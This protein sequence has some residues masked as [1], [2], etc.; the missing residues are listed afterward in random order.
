MTDCVAFMTSAG[1][2]F[3][4]GIKVRMHKQS[5]RNAHAVIFVSFDKHQALPERKCIPAAA[6]RREQSVNIALQPETIVYWF[7]TDRCVLANKRFDF[8]NTAFYLQGICVAGR[9]RQ[10]DGFKAELPKLSPRSV[11]AGSFL[12]FSSRKCVLTLPLTTT[13]T[14]RERIQETNENPRKY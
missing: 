13:S 12:Y 1:M 6:A 2:L 9:W 5:P 7:P 4:A 3:C 10:A 11:Q 14:C 8:P